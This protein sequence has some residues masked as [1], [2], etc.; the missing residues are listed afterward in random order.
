ALDGYRLRRDGERAVLRPQDQHVLRRREEGDV[1]A[2][3]R[4]Q[5]A[6]RLTT[7]GGWGLESGGGGWNPREPKGRAP[8]W[9][10]ERGACDERR[11]KTGAAGAPEAS[12]IAERE[13]ADS[14]APG[15][16]RG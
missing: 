11:G 5:D 10:E 7:P 16:E 4:G 9:T 3:R 14:R 1:R 8:V 13:D 12:G 2:D 6:G 15:G